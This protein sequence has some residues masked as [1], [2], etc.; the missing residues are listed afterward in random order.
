MFAENACYAR[1]VEVMAF[2]KWYSGLQRLACLSPVSHHE[3][4]PLFLVCQVLVHLHI[5][6]SP[7]HESHDESDAHLT[8]NLVAALKSFLVVAEYLDEVVHASKESQPY[9]GDDHQE[10]I[11]VAQTSEQQHRNEY[12]DNDYDATH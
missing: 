1:V 5:R 3:F 9:S 2:D 6:R 4:M 12:R 10:Q 7:Q 8:D 11:N